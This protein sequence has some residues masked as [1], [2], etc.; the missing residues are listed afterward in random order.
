M[1]MDSPRRSSP[2]KRFLV[3]PHLLPPL[4]LIL[5]KNK[6]DTEGVVKIDANS[7]ENAP[8]YGGV[9]VET[10]WFVRL[11]FEFEPAFGFMAN[12]PGF[13]TPNSSFQVVYLMHK[14]S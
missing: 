2:S 10:R 9:P 14:Y 12:A 5:A 7:I 13:S 8:I 11:L 3:N 1:E 4:K 6:N